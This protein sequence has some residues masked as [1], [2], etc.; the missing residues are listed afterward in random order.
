MK[1]NL[2]KTILIVLIALSSG[3]SYAATF[4][5]SDGNTNT[6]A[7]NNDGTN[8]ATIT[9]VNSINNNDLIIPLAQGQ[10]VIGFFINTGSTIACNIAYMNYGDTGSKKVT[11]SFGDDTPT[12]IMPTTE[13]GI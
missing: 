8:T 13:H 9:G 6:W 11:L 1:H 3:S 2:L 10:T 12:A 5:A 4:V 7:A